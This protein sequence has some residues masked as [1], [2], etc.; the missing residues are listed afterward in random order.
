MGKPTGFLEY[1]R[2]ANP[3][4]D[5]D[6]RIKDYFE[7]HSTLN[8]EER[9]NQAARCMDCGVPYCQSALSIKNR[10]VG[11]P[12][13]NLIPEWNDEIYH[14]HLVH[15]LS[16]LLKTNNFPEFTSRVCPALCEKACL[17]GV[18]GE[19]VTIHDNENYII[20][21]AYAAG[22]MKPRIPAKRS[23]KKVAVI[24][25]GP[26]GLACADELN[27]RG[28]SVDVYE[29]EDRVGGLLMYGIPNMKLDK[30]V[31]DRRIKIME[32]EG[33]HFI[34]SANV[35]KDVKVKALLDDYDA[36]VLCVGAKEPRKLKG[37]SLKT[38]GV[39]YAVDY[40]TASTK[41][42]LAKKDDTEAKDKHVVIVGGGD[43]GNDCVATAIRHHAKS[44]VQLEMM[45]EPPLERTADNPW[46]EWPNVKKTDYGQKEAIAV[47][48]HDPRV[49]E[50][51][52]K[53]VIEEKGA[54]KK[55][56]TVQVRFE[57][58]KIV[59]VPGSEK[60]LDCDLLIIAA[61]FVGINGYVSKAFNLNV[62]KRNTIDAKDNYQCGDTKV[63]AAGDGRRGQSLV[64]WAIT[65]GRG[66]AKS[67]DDYLMGYSTMR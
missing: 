15:A 20:E 40:L 34:T 1:E 14:G 54:I 49:Y 31:I 39:H 63:F 10:V 29:R 26:S 32:E 22:L 41:N 17:N 27:H 19:S 36:V 18:D 23:G 57:A 65:E 45:G 11:C 2:C 61:G 56:V 38:K 37:V 28:H 66:C 46:P 7:F 33:V 50:T 48:G 43:T 21:S 62:T 30:S 64:V 3:E 16:R 8:S 25:S 51:T 58:G 4:R 60:T 12:L 24:G 44:V 5:I 67:V 13:H 35:G 55:I 6:E 59:E 47:F 42:V 9:K 53:E 52:V